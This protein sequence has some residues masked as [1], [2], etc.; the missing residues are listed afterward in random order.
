MSGANIAL[1]KTKGL[2]KKKFSKTPKSIKG[3]VAK[4]SK[5][6]S[7]IKKE[8]NSAIEIKNF[9]TS[10]TTPAL[11]DNLGT[12]I[13]SV[14]IPAQG[15]G[16]QARVGDEV[17]PSSINLRYR[18]NMNPSATGPGA[19][20]VQNLV[21]V[22]L[23][24]DHEG[25]MVSTDLLDS[26]TLGGALAPYSMY[27]RASRGAFTIV[28]DKLHSIDVVENVQEVC[29][30]NLKLNKDVRFAPGT[31]TVERNLLRIFVCSD[32]TLATTATQKPQFSMNCRVWYKDA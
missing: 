4:L 8:M 6:V 19:N 28:Y 22:I 16:N 31:S 11:L 26:F 10:L 5:T 12:F 27:P 1:A 3:K 2:K 24:W 15:V 23:F 21:R 7:S 20:S 18:V 25:N 14:F 13:A 9:D 17:Q 30:L 29:S 32:N